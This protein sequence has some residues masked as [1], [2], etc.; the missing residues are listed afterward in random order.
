[1]TAVKWNAIRYRIRLRGRISGLVVADLNEALWPVNQA[2]SNVKI[3]FNR[4][5]EG[6]LF[7]AISE[8]N[9]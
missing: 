8:I 6:A 9:R 5:G 3:T 7:R 4:S 2:L 1:M